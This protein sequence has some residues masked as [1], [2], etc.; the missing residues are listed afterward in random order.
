MLNLWRRWQAIDFQV[1]TRPFCCS[2]QIKLNLYTW[3]PFLP[4][5]LLFYR[6]FHVFLTIAICNYLCF[7]GEVV[8]RFLAF[9]FI[10][11]TTRISNKT[12][13][14]CKRLVVKKINLETIFPALQNWNVLHWTFKAREFSLEIILDYGKDLLLK[15]WPQLIIVCKIK[16]WT[17]F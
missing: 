6:R 12:S 17:Q 13:F 10:S 16:W 7:A 4:N 14:L 11:H 15:T 1:P 2:V 3:W 8:F 5:L 9:G